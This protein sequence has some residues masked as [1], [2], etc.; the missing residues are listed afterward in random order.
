[1]L[2]GRATGIYYDVPPNRV[3][4]A[5]Y[6][7]VIVPQDNRAVIPDADPPWTSQAKNVPRALDVVEYKASILCGCNW[8]SIVKALQD[9]LLIVTGVVQKLRIWIQNFR[10]QTLW[11]ICSKTQLHQSSVHL[12]KFINQVEHEYHQIY[13]KKYHFGART[14]SFTGQLGYFMAAVWG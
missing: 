9:V 12:A 14:A 3:A 1:M 7:Y 11:P 2:H 5:L 8:C 4:N 13:N 10:N 6:T